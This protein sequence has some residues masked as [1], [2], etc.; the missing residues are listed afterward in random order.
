MMSETEILVKLLE[1]TGHWIST[2]E[3]DRVL[4]EVWGNDHDAKM[5]CNSMLR[6]GLIDYHCDGDWTIDIT[7]EELELEKLEEELES[8]E[9]DQPGPTTSVHGSDGSDG[10]RRRYRRP[11]QF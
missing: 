5:H 6:R 7:L 1:V 8:E 2:K 9:D 10:L 4:L 11:P 3:L